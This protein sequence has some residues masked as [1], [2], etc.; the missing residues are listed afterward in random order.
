MHGAIF[1]C[2]QVPF[3]FDMGTK[4]TLDVKGAQRVQVCTGRDTDCKRMG[5]FQIMCFCLPKSMKHL[6]PRLGIIFPGK[7]GKFYEQE[8]KKYDPRVI[9]MFQAKAWCD[10]PT[11]RSYVQ[12]IRTDVAKLRSAVGAKHDEMGLAFLD[13]L[14]A[15]THTD[16]IADQARYLRQKCWFGPP[17]F[18]SEWQVIDAG[19]G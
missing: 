2:M 4:D 5:T 10:R 17:G 6:Q 16:H 19:V 7:G 9:V 15:Q 8:Q 1:V 18:T 14:D 12:H 13:N 11:A 3:N